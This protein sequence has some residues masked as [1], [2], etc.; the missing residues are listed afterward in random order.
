MFGTPQPFRSIST[1]FGISLVAA[2]ATITATLESGSLLLLHREVSSEQQRNNTESKNQKD[3]IADAAKGGDE[4]AASIDSGHEVDR[5]VLNVGGYSYATTCSVLLSSHHDKEE[6][7]NNYFQALLSYHWRN[8][9]TKTSNDDHRGLPCFDIG[10]DRD[11]DIFFHVLCYLRIADI[12]RHLKKDTLY[13]TLLSISEVK[14]LEQEVGYYGLHGLEEMCQKAQEFLRG[15]TESTG[16]LDLA[17]YQDFEW[18]IENECSAV[19]QDYSSYTLHY[20]C[21]DSKVR[22]FHHHQLGACVPSSNIAVYAK[23]SADDVEKRVVDGKSLVTTFRLLQAA[24]EK[25]HKDANNLEAS[26]I[27]TVTDVLAKVGSSATNTITVETR[28]WWG[29][30]ISALLK[31]Y[32]KEKDWE[33]ECGGKGKDIIKFLGYDRE[34]GNALFKSEKPGLTAL[35]SCYSTALTGVLMVDSED[36]SV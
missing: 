18:N 3:D 36:K 4:V 30:E 28:L 14:R 31:H 16:D 32:K 7:G 19:S 25:L 11:G 24:I 9:K 21:N 35:F 27:I 8:T 20:K 29:M 23:T 5:V 1:L 33:F 13:D 26:P 15:W 6:E 2:K 12:P 10:Q 34:W 22:V 17:P